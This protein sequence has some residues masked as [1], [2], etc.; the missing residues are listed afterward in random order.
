MGTLTRPVLIGLALLAA[1]GLGTLRQ[2]ARAD[3]NGE[4]VHVLKEIAQY[5]RTSNDALRSQADSVR[6]LTRIQERQADSMRELV[7]AAERCK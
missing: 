5:Q 3:S 1:Y 7:R 4:L 6:E 2:P